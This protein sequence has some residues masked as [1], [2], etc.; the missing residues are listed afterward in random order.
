VNVEFR[1]AHH[2]AV[3]T[4]IHHK[5]SFSLTDMHCDYILAVSIIG[6]SKIAS[7]YS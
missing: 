4:C 1:I 7:S 3:R 5:Q 6:T 2:S